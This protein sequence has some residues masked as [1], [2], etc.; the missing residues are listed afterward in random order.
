V[1]SPQGL[2]SHPA[3]LT[4]A[5][6]RQD[7]TFSPSA[8]RSFVRELKPVPQAET[9]IASRLTFVTI[10]RNVPLVEAGC[11]NRYTFLRF[12]KT[13]IFFD[14]ALDYPNQIDLLQEI[15]L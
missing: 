4:P 11:W 1:S 15:T 3:N 14:R 8:S 12:G 9:S 10:G 5:S 6:G 13:E 2:T 7:H